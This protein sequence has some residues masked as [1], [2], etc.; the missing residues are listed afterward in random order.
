MENNVKQQLNVCQEVAIQK[1]MIL[2]SLSLSEKILQV[3]RGSM[4][5]YLYI[6]SSSLVPKHLFYIYLL[7]LNIASN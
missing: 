7:T 6:E 2:N 4:H 3:L 5:I 1:D